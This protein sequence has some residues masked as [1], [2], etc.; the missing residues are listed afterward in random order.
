MKV[1]L[2][3]LAGKPKAWLH[4]LR[5]PTGDLSSP[6]GRAR[7]RRRRATLS[8]MMS[9]LAKIVSVGTALVSVPIT[10]HYLGN[11]RYGMWMI[12]SSMVAML[13]F[14]D[15][16]MGNGILSMVATAY[17]RN[18]M[19]EI[20]SVVSS[21][22]VM[23]TAVAVTV[24]C[25]FGIAYPHVDW[26]K[27]FNVASPSARAEAGPAVAVFAIGFAIA[28]PTSVIQ[29]VQMGLQ[30]GFIAS[31]WLCGGSVLAL[32]NVLIAVWLQ[33]SLPWLV[34][35]FLS[36]PIVAN[37]FNTLVFF[38]STRPDS[39]PT[40]RSANWASGRQVLRTGLL[41]LLLQVAGAMMFNSH[42]VIIAQILG[43][44]SVPLFA[45]PDRLFSLVTMTV[46]MA[47][48]PLWPAYRESIERGD[49]EWAQRTLKRSLVVAVTYAASLAVP[50]I[51]ISPWILH[52]WVGR[53]V[54]PPFAL[55]LGLGIWKIFEA[56]GLAL[57]MFLNGAHVIKPQVIFTGAT[58]IAS[59]TLELFLVR[60]IGVAGSVWATLIAFSVLTLVPYAFLTPKILRELSK[61]PLEGLS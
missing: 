47:L 14:A 15:L 53:G 32:C 18:D 42:N 26:F 60:T 12:M 21:G 56:G 40:I 61:P 55:L 57:G 54:R 29:R 38:G 19:E 44:A 8:A 59:I 7:E 39:R 37:I 34:A 43:A 20:Q 16:G 23:L 2:R 25:A 27:L 24:V 5:M 13:S 51:F 28:I 10:L 11:E 41:F 9:M 30:N 50:L 1:S 48:T 36:G 45:V 33:A 31:M 4:A 17:S 35:A 58:A 46:T 3:S 6:E 49:S 22:L 52:Y